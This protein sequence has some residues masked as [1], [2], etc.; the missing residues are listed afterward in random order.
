[1]D[2]LYQFCERATTRDLYDFAV[3]HKRVYD[4]CNETLREKQE[5]RIKQYDSTI[6]IN[7]FLGTLRQLLKRT[8]T[9][10]KDEAT[11]RITVTSQGKEEF[12]I[13]LT[14]TIQEESKDNSILNELADVIW[15]SRLKLNP[16]SSKGMIFLHLD[17]IVTSSDDFK[18]KLKDIL[19]ELSKRGYTLN[20]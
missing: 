8:L 3:S 6:F 12:Q 2:E 7:N 4:V 11:F 1:M 14:E 20:P 5:Q 9:F 18:S 17:I 15:M 16:I 19:R 13:K 10:S